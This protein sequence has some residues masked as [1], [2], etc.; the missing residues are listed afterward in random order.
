MTPTPLEASLR[1]VVAELT[2]LG[3]AFALVGGLAASARVDPRLTRAADLAVSVV[4]DADAETLVAELRN[5][6]EVLAVVKQEETGR[7]ATARLLERT[8]IDLWS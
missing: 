6:Y 2:R 3:R 8:K 7:L 1:A 5:R 4:D